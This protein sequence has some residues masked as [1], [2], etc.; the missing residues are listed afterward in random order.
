MTDADLA[1]TMDAAWEAR[2]SL[3]PSTRGAY[4]DA[5]EEALDGLDSGRRVRSLIQHAGPKLSGYAISAATRAT[6]IQTAAEGRLRSGVI[7]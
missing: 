3:A 1:A 7:A 5:V 4:R 2:D 6:L